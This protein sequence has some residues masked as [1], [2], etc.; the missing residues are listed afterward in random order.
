MADVNYLKDKEKKYCNGCGACL[1]ICPKGAISMK[2]DEEGFF[3]PEVD[4]TKCINCGLC[5]KVCSFE[6]KPEGYA[7]DKYVYGG[8]HKDINVTDKS[9]SGGAFTAIVDAFCDS[10]YVIFGATSD[11]LNVYHTYI[12]DKKDIDKFRKSKYSQSNIGETYK[13]VKEFLKNGKKVLFS[14]T[15]CQIT[16]LR[17]FLQNTDTANLLTVEVVCEGLPSPIYINKFCEKLEKK[18]NSKVKKID[19][20]YKDTKKNHAKW[21]FEIMEIELENG[22]VLKIDRWFNPFWQIWLKHLMSRPSCYN[23]NWATTTRYADITLGDL[24]G[25][26][27]YCKDLYG[28]NR[29]ASLILGNTKKG[30]KIIIEAKKYLFGHEL[31]FSDALKYQSPLRKK[32]DYNSDREKFME[33]LTSN[34][35]YD[36]IN[37][38]W[39]IKPSTKLLWSKYVWGNRQK[40]FIYNLGRKK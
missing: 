5:H 3:Y 25:V 33:D 1:N 16:G 7:E 18:Y 2:K 34:M 10:N 32:I 11:G 23:C 20:R 17:L 14:G 27:L 40:M 22:K 6:N 4:E 35:A 8:Y 21:D 13:K 9:T 31:V 12:M 36:D 30:K 15:P 38:K 19:Y 28:K 29:G 26:H 37:K 24:W 39:Y